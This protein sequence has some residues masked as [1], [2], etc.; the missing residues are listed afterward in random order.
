MTEIT[1][2]YL[3]ASSFKVTGSKLDEFSPGRAVWANCGADGVKYA[4]VASSSY[5]A[6]DTTVTLN[7]VESQSLTENLASVLFGRVKYGITKG[8]E[9]LQNLWAMRGHK[10]GF[11]V[12]CKDA[13]EIYVSP[14]VIHISAGSSENI[15]YTSSTITKQ[16][17]SLAQSTW[18]GIYVKPPSSGLL[19]SADDIEY[20]PT[21]SEP[22]NDAKKMGWYHQEHTNRRCIGFVITDASS[23]IIPFNTAG[24]AVYLESNPTVYI[25]TPSTTW[26]EV[27]ANVPIGNMAAICIMCHNYVS[28]NAWS[29]YRKKGSTSNGNFGAYAASVGGYWGIVKCDVKC[30]SSKKFEVKITEAGSNTLY[31]I[32]AGYHLPDGF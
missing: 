11:V 3:S 23:N 1:A 31:I 27:V 20:Y 13:D 19:I 25:G 24:T 12:S 16:L 32:G 4:F 10:K 18:Y 7:T 17:T 8:N 2:T 22:I 9:P 5:S 26:T 30:D 21:S 15:Y 14:G 6:P 28:I 29:L